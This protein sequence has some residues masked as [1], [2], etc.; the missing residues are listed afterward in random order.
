MAAG[1]L[2]REEGDGAGTAAGGAGLDGDAAGKGPADASATNG[3]TRHDEWVRI[4][5]RALRILTLSS[6]SVDTPTQALAASLGRI[7]IFLRVRRR[8]SCVGPA[9]SY[10]PAS[11]TDSTRI[12]RHFRHRR[13]VGWAR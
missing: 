1:R 4:P 13:G 7:R 2:P 9:R 8:A 3:A 12:S 5:V 10:A 11:S 6:D